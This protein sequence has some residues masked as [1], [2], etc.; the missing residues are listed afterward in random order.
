LKQGEALSPLLFNFAR[1][2][3]IRSVQLNQD[4]LKLNGTHHLLFY[5]DDGNVLGGSIPS[6][7]N[8]DALVAAS[9]EIIPLVVNGEKNSPTATYAGHRR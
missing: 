5:A 7:K 4:G 6:I 8:T 3:V 2:C 1:V 9:K